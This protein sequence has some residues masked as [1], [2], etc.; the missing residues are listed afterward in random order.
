MET[1]TRVY[2]TNPLQ[3]PR[4]PAGVRTPQFG[5]RCVNLW[6]HV[7]NLFRKVDL[8]VLFVHLQCLSQKHFR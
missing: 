6:G 2:H 8:D 4:E 1:A 7:E 3:F 5:K